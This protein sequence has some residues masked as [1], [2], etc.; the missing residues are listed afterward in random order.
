M[1][2]QRFGKSSCV[3][4][5]EVVLST[6]LGIALLLQILWIGRIV[7]TSSAAVE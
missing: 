2:D 5:R 4:C 1:D 3:L 7:G 6:I